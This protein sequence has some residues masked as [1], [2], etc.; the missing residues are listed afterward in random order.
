MCTCGKTVVMINPVVCCSAVDHLRE[1]VFAADGVVEE[2]FA[3]DHMY[4]HV[5]SP[6]SHSYNTAFLFISCFFSVWT[7]LKA[8]VALN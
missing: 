2:Y 7:K 4:V 8:I 5:Y 1:E 6:Y 3:Y